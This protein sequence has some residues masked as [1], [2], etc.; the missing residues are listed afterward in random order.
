MNI[1]MRKNLG[2]L[3]GIFGLALLL[4]YTTYKAGFEAMPTSD[5]EGET[6]V[7]DLPIIVICI[8]CVCSVS[9]YVF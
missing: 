8:Y 9:S 1:W 3:L 4:V 5:K 7:P 6:R 2:K